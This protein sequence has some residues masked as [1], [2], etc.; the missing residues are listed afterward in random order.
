MFPESAA[1]AAPVFGADGT[2]AAAIAVGAPAERLQPRIAEL[3]PV[4]AD[5]AARASG[6]AQ[7]H[8]ETETPSPRP[9][10]VRKRAAAAAISE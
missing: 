4:I 1:I 7:S 3:G 2:I 9:R 8:V 10:P 5:V 6:Q